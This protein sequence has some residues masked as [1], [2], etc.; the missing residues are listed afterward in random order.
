[1]QFPLHLRQH[2][3]LIKYWLR[4]LSMPNKCMIKRIYDELLTLA[5]QGHDNFAKKINSIFTQYNV[6]K[7]EIPTSPHEKITSFERKFR[8]RRYLQYI[9]TWRVSICQY[10]KLGFY[11]QIK[12]DYRVEPHILYV[13]NKMSNRH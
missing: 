8:E 5:E 13:Q 6:S 1:M 3:Q 9:N 11:R 12:K 7:A 2:D 10:P 4:I